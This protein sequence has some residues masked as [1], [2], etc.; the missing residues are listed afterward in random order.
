LRWHA[1]VMARP[2]E[3]TVGAKWVDGA[4]DFWMVL[5][6]LGVPLLLAAAYVEANITP[7][8]ILWVFGD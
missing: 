2:D 6:G 5:L 8:I 7:H 4:A 3:G 1:T